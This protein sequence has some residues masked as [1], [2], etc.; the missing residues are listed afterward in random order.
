MAA[1]KWTSRRARFWSLIVLSL[2]ATSVAL[3]PPRH[4]N[5]DNLC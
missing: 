4:E 1:M 5:Y 3:T 2:V